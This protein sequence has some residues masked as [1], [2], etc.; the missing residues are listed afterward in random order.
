MLASTSDIKEGC[1]T[2]YV[3][4]IGDDARAGEPTSVW[5]PYLD[6]AGDVV[7][8][9]LAS[10]RVSFLPLGDCALEGVVGWLRTCC[11]I[12]GVQDPAGGSEGGRAGFD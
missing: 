5:P 1:C 2:A 9:F 6:G 8:V 10:E 4:D 12:C 11:G 3:P 7:G